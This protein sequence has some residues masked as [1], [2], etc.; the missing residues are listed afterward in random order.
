M[1][2]M[3]SAY[4][5]EVHCNRYVEL[6]LVYSVSTIFHQIILKHTF[7]LWIVL[8]L[9]LDWKVGWMS[10]LLI[11]DALLAEESLCLSIQFIYHIFQVGLIEEHLPIECVHVRSAFTEWGEVLIVYL[12]EV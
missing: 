11:T 4:A 8:V 2:D 3:V 9:V 1:V 12:E 5:L 6:E 10:R 7:L